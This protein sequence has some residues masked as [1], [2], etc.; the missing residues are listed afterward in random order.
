MTRSCCRD[1]R[2]H[3]VTG[4]GFIGWILSFAKYPSLTML[5]FVQA[6]LESGEDIFPPLIRKYLL[7]NTHRVSVVMQ[8]DTDLAAQQE[9]EEKA[10]LEA[11]RAVW[12]PQDIDAI[13]EKTRE[14][15]ERQVNQIPI[16]YFEFLTTRSQLCTRRSCLVPGNL[17]WKS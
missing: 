15:K 16:W 14:L 12:S 5:R 4:V 17:T 7:D 6:R 9:A 2:K 3:R 11:V 8:P 10:K 1:E 13:I